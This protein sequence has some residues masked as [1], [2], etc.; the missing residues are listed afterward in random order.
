[1][2]FVALF[3]IIL[4]SL[5]QGAK[6]QSCTGGLGDPIV[7][8]TF[9]KGSGPGGALAPGITNLTWQQGGCPSDGYYAIV[10]QT[11]GCFGDTWITVPSD[12]TGDGGYFM[13]INASFDPSDFYVQQIDGLC[14]GTSYQFAAWVLNMAART[15]Q[16]RP[17]ITFTI[18]KTDGT[19]L[20]S[21]TTGDIQPA[22]YVKWV[23]YGFFFNT[24]PGIS[25]VVIRMTNN[26][27]GGTGN[28]LALDDITFRAAGPAIQASI[29]GYADDN[30]TLCQP[31]V[32]VL[33]LQATV[34]N[35]Y[36]SAVYQWQQSIDGGTTWSDIPGA[37]NTSWPR[38]PTIPGVYQYRL[39]VA[40]SGNGGASSC[41][42]V[43]TPI[44]VTVLATPAPAVTIAS[45]SSQ[46]C[47]GA[48]A[49]F[50]ATSVDGGGAPVFQWKVN[51]QDAG[52]GTTTY[53]SSSLASTD[54]VSCEMTSDAACTINP[55]VASNDLS[56]DVIPIPV[57][58]VAIAASATDICADSV[59]TFT[60]T[61][62]NGGGMP[63]YQWEIDGNIIDS[64]GPVLT[65]GHFSDGDIVSCTM[66]GSLTCSPPVT[67]PEPIRMTVRPLPVIT[68]TP[69]TV[70][71]GGQTI[72]L[73][74][75]VSG[76]IMTWA[77]SPATALSDVSSPDPVATPVS[78]TSYHLSVVSTAGCRASASELVEVFYEVQLPGAFSPNGDGRNDVFRIPPSIA[79][80]LHGLVVYNRWGALLF[81][82]ADSGA[83]WDGT[84][85]GRPQP[86]GVYVWEVEYD[87][88]LTRKVEGRR[89]TVVLVR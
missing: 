29:A 69:D 71:A 11:A 72:R 2:K 9:G 65:Y 46:L 82:T 47:A 5:S 27:P 89:G 73:S 53:T 7:N 42:V 28:D 40:Q 38:P 45:A 62:G 81:S 3:A 35:C 21:Y 14:T 75:L 37:T 78:S 41:E 26:A 15:D 17:N 54:V 8:I 68:L 36:P 63:V 30:V 87:N 25:S 57:T 6:A 34:E 59:V 48:P 74:P 31:D 12:H 55:S 56:V 39:A 13:L 66:T 52:T 85:H 24:P 60:A 1:M 64:A 50:T 51:G 58:S 88:P 77:W 79:I 80:H 43:S 67:S 18:E 23:Q 70:I 16:I 44:T 61:P 83:G 32:R 10:G 19:V 33:T 49:V 76:D 86:A 84:F 20:Q 4:F 22:T